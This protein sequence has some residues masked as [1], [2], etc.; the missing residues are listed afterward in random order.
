MELPLE[1]SFKQSWMTVERMSLLLGMLGLAFT[2]GSQWSRVDAVEAASNA[3]R[4]Q[5]QTLQAQLTADYARKD[6]LEERLLR[7]QEQLDL[8]LLRAR[9]R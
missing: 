7:I 3:T 9:Q 4:G 8:L 6:V 2:A 1:S 5:M